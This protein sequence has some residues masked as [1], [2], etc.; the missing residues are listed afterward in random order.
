MKCRQCGA[1]FEGNF[2]PYCGTKAE[3]LNRTNIMQ[4][5]TPAPSVSQ[6]QPFGAANPDRAAVYFLEKDDSNHQMKN[7]LLL[8]LVILIMVFFIT[9][10]LI[11]SSAWFIFSDYRTPLVSAS[12]S[13]GVP[14]SNSSRVPSS[15]SNQQAVAV[16]TVIDIIDTQIKENLG[17]PYQISYTNSQIEISIW[18]EGVAQDIRLAA[19]GNMQG[20]SW[21][22]TVVDSFVE[23]NN[24]F[25]EVLDYYDLDNVTLII[26]ILND[27][28]HDIKLLTIVDGV[29][30]Y[31]VL[32]E[33]V[34]Q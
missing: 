32:E 8:T 22:E 16:A 30:T 34:K 5:P 20:I 10:P 21:W 13:F 2:C 4:N 15:S 25:G 23:I 33:L 29:V 14:S 9:L 7:G 24:I 12:S 27:E 17:V 1:D 31:D 6:G 28:D 11:L 26:H 19:S 18:T 3:P